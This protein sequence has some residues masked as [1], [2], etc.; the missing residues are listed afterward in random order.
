MLLIRFQY[1]VLRD[2]IGKTL[3]IFQI[4]MLEL[5]TEK[6]EYYIVCHYCYNKKVGQVWV[7]EEWCC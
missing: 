4:K 1:I 6:L 7:L 3:N 5:N 2:K